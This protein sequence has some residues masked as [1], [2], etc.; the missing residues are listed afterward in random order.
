MIVCT[1]RKSFI[2]KN[3]AAMVDFFEDMLRVVRWY[4]DPKNHDEAV[5]DRVEADQNSAGALLLAVHRQGLRHATA[6]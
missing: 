5:R 1:A 6:T 4:L 2:D 3:R